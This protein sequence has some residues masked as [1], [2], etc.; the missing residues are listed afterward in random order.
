MRYRL[1]ALD[2][3][4]TF[5]DASGMPSRENL[6]AVRRAQ[7]AGA[8]V[9]PCTGRSWGESQAPLREFPRVD[10]DH[11]GVFV[12]GAVVTHMDSGRHLDLSVIEPHLAFELVTL[13]ADMPEAVLVLRDSSITGHDYLV[14]GRGGLTRDTQRWF[15]TFGA[16][17]R[18]QARLTPE[19]L[20]HTLRVGMVALGEQAGVA[21]KRIKQRFD[22]QVVMLS[23]LAWQGP[24]PEESVH[25]FEVFAQGV[26]KWR[27]IDWIAR[28]RG[29]APQEVAAIGDEANDLSMIRRAGCGIAMGNAIEPV[30]QVARYVTRTNQEHGVAHAIDQLLRGAWT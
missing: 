28:A 30:K 2:L 19:D 16:N 6:E 25:V 18:F 17:V 8:L 10:G 29:I 20:H 27:G 22:G 14:T 12:T 9:V 21:A 13:L 15:Q 11:P 4:G 5:L 3:D 23:I 1:I 7:Q 26:D 24:T